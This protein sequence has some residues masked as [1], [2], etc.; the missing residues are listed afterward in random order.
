MKKFKLYL[1]TSIFNFAIADDVP[2][3]KS[4]TLSLFDEIKKGKHEIFISEVV[5]L[6]VGKAPTKVADSLQRL[7]K[8]LNPVEL[9]VDEEI[10]TLADEYIKYGI[11]P[12][13]Y[14]NDA[15]H[16]AIASVNDLD[17]IVSWNFKHIVKV[18]TKREVT[19]V[20]VLMGYK[21]IEIY[22]PLEITGNV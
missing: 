5:I 18:R 1:D 7:I 19:G 20:N 22:S 21:E 15:L 13:K 8:Q 14:E 4:V 16:I 10:Q 12:P 9:A 6:E 3:E 2:H 11:V 17:V